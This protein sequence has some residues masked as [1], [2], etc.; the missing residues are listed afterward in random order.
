MSCHLLYEYEKALQI[1]EEF[2]KTQQVYC[3]TILVCYFKIQW[4]FKFYILIH[5]KWNVV[6]AFFIEKCPAKKPDAIF[7][8]RRDII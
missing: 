4:F 6:F 7:Y 2:R 5:L 1:L 8:G 3:F